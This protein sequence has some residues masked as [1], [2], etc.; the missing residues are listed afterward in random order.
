MFEISN[1]RRPRAFTGPDS[2]KRAERAG[3]WLRAL[4]G[5]SR[6]VDWCV[7]RNIPLTKAQVEGVN[8]AGGYLVPEELDGAILAAREAAGA[9][10]SGCDIRRMTSATSVRPRRAGGLTAYFTSEGSAISES[11]MTWDAISASAKKLAILGRSSSELWEDE[12]EILSEYIA[13]EAGFAFALKED[14]VGFGSGVSDGITGL[15]KALSGTTSAIETASGHNSFATLDSSDLAGLIAGVQSSA[16]ASAAWYCSSIC[17]ALTICRLA[18]TT[19]GLVATP[20]PDGST[21]LS[22]LGWPVRISSALATA[23]TALTGSAMLFFGD[24]A[25]S[26]VLAQRSGLVVAISM[27]RAMDADQVLFRAIE[28]LDIVNHLGVSAPSTDKTPVA[29]LVGKS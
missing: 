11:Q 9:F 1:A 22:Y 20:Q 16:L 15:E 25:R 29:M 27:D 18:G 13:A 19:G 5:D 6:A 8:V 17:F 7:T 2:A 14:T 10:R 4:I 28:R 12:P 23:T 3:M 21:R 24:L 26:S